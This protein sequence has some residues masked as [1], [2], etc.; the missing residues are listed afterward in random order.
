[1]SNDEQMTN[2]N[3]EEEAARRFGHFV[4]RASFV[5]RHS[6]LVITTRL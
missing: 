4:I 6:S 2:P 3:D 5:I 1:M